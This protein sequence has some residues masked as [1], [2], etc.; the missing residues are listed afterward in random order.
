MGPA[1]PEAAKAVAEGLKAVQKDT[2][3]EQYTE[4]LEKADFPLKKGSD[5]KTVTWPASFS[6]ESEGTLY[7][8]VPVPHALGDYIIV[9]YD[10][11]TK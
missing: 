4:C 6:Y 3:V 1:D 7:Y 10:I 2:T 5:G 8:S 9:E 11:T